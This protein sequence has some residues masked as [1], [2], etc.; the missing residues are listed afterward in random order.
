MSVRA[1]VLTVRAFQVQSTE[2]RAV[3]LY[4]HT[5][6]VGQLGGHSECRGGAAWA[7]LQG[8]FRYAGWEPCKEIKK[9]GQVLHE[10]ATECGRYF[11]G[12]DILGLMQGV[13]ALRVGRGFVCCLRKEGMGYVRF[14][15]SASW[16]GWV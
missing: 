1:C 16:T 15:E 12:Q 2:A 3:A 11:I 6:L 8:V 7:A 9:A 5:E 13:P 10:R 4:G 14:Q